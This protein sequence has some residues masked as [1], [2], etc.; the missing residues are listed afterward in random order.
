M[1]R[2][3]DKTLADILRKYGADPK[4]DV[5]DCHGTW[6]AYHRALERIAVQAGITFAPPQVL[7]AN[8]AGKCV[9][10]CVTG[11][12]DGRSEW[13]IGEAAPGNNKN[14][15][16]F[17]MAEKRAKDR[18]ILKLIG[19][20]GLVYSEDEM[21][22]A[23]PPKADPRQSQAAAPPAATIPRASKEQFIADI[24][25]NIACFDN[26]VSLGQWWNSEKAKEERRSFG[27][28]PSEVNALK[29]E[30]LARRDELTKEAA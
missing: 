20:H 5:W 26:A 1:A 23:T 2:T 3:I 18:V 13:S 17:A 6:V 10:L 9:A 29:A 25:A 21:E 16:P 27:L 28:D 24:R 22:D 8:G 7:E 15:Y 30:V 14:G 12:M 11:T 19:L 4:T